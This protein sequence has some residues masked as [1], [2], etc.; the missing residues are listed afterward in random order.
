MNTRLDTARLA[1]LV[2][3]VRSPVAA[4]SAIEEAIAGG[5]VAGELRRD[6]VRLVTLAC[7]GIERIVADAAVASIRVDRVDAERLV[8]DVVASARLRGITV[9]LDVVG[10]LPMIDADASRLR[11]VL[12]NLITNA[13]VHGPPDGPVTV[14][15]EAGEWLILSVSDTGDGIA[16]DDLERVFEVGVSRDRAGGRGLGLAL[17]RALVEGQGGSLSVVSTTG[18][19]A[20]FTVSLPLRPG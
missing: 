4:L 15:A 18:K 14:M 16:P 8:R 2:H 9:I 17:A 10:P 12:D 5:E 1:V 7:L 6:L 20:T 11:Q 13:V 3:E 19:G